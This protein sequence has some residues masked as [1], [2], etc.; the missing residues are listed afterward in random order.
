MDLFDRIMELSRYGYFCSQILGILALEVAGEENPDLVKAMGG[1]DGGVGYSK[2]CCGCMTGGA[3][4]ISYFTGKGGA[5]EHESPAHKPALAE[6]TQWFQD[7]ITAD[8]GGINCEDI[9]GTNPAKRVEYCP[10]IIAASFE[11]CMEI[12]QEKGLV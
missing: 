2:G 5:F 4:V 8:Y 9:I 11:K 3:C 7:E 6:F 1:L 12:L 10:Q